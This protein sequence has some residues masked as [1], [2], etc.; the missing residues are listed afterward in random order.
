MQRTHVSKF[1]KQPTYGSPKSKTSWEMDIKIMQPWSVPVF[2]THLPS[3]VLEQMTKLSDK[4]I[5]DKDAEKM[6]KTLAGQVKS[7]LRLLPELLKEKDL[8][9]MN[10]FSGMIREFVI[11]CKC[12]QYPNKAA[13]F[14][15]RENWLVQMTEAWITSQMPGEYNP[16]HIHAGCHLSAVMYIKIPK[17]LPSRKKQTT[18]D[19]ELDGSLL[20]SSNASRDIVLSVPH[21]TV[22]PKVGDFFIFSSHQEH[23]VYPYRCEE[24]DRERRSISFNAI[25]QSKADFDRGKKLET[26]QA[27]VAPGDSRPS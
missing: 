20:F 4:I 22:S 8:S 19:A 5:A 6:G 3:E 21:I 12:Q 14:T 10:F 11:A 24:G 27:V 9:A 1:K 17:M 23:L 16:T 26:P 13:Q 18:E 25:F 7:E 15:N 2:H